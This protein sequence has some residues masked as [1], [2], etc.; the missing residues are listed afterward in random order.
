M[1]DRP[2]DER[3]EPYYRDQ[4]QTHPAMQDW[5]RLH[6]SLCHLGREIIAPVRPAIIAVL[7]RLLSVIEW[8]QGRG[9]GTPRL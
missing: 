5:Q 6:D 3:R 9:T 7:D 2:Q 8:W 1:T 4:R